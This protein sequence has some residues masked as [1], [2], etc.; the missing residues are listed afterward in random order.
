MNMDKFSALIAE[1]LFYGSLPSW[2]RIPV[3]A[4]VNE[5]IRRNRSI[6]DIAYV[7]ATGYHE[8]GRWKYDEE[9]GEGRGRDYGEPIWLIRG[10][11]VT[12]HG[13][14]DVQLTWLHNYAKMSVF[15]TLEHQRE[16]NLVSNPD[17]VKEPEFASLVIW[18]GMVRGMFTGRNLADYIRPGAADY[19]EARRIVN[20]TDQAQR[21][22][23]YARAFETD[24]RAA[25]AEA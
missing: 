25:K 6:E 10:K 21:I 7:L 11:R 4:I 14:G 22:A 1:H 19:V 8:T 13:R 17:L 24:L 18:E 15:L 5:G 16:I 9:I 2:Q 3:F 23:G 20:G 12:Y